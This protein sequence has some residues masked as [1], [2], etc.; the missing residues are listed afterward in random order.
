MWQ[1]KPLNLG[2]KNPKRERRCRFYQKIKIVI[3]L[4]KGKV[5]NNYN[6]V[7]S[8]IT[9]GK[10]LL[11]NWHDGSRSSVV[12][13]SY[14]TTRRSRHDSKWWR[15]WVSTTSLCCFCS[16]KAVLMLLPECGCIPL[17]S[18][19]C[20]GLGSFN[21]LVHLLHAFSFVFE[22]LVAM[23]VFEQDFTLM[24]RRRLELN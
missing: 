13:S 17:H 16:L 8:C 19:H 3:D 5:L 20:T 9:K 21:H 1:I 18:S 24:G 2:K 6:K 4:N 15:W 23:Y 7:S 12:R 11:T 10:M 14:M 22:Y